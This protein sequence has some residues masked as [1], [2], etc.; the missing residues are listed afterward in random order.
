MT[1]CILSYL[2]F[3]FCRD[4]ET[5]LYKQLLFP[6]TGYQINHA[7]YQTSTIT[8]RRVTRGPMVKRDLKMATLDWAFDF[9]TVQTVT[10]ELKELT[11]HTQ[12]SN[13]T[14]VR[15]IHILLHLVG[16]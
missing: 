12:I 6:W 2:L 7:K 9:N 10:D 16:T 13:A 5:P 15:I 3:N 4:N 8:A 14:W 11:V 1:D